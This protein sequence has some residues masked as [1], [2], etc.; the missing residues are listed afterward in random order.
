MGRATHAQD[1]GTDHAGRV[2]TDL[3]GRRRARSRFSSLWEFSLFVVVLL[4]VFLVVVDMA[5]TRGDDRVLRAA[6]SETASALVAADADGPADDPDAVDPN[7][8]DPNAAR[9]AGTHLDRDDVADDDRCEPVGLH[10]VGLADADA[11][12]TDAICLAKL[13]TKS[14]RS[15][16]RV[17][18]ERGESEVTVC[19]MAAARS[20]TGL[21]APFQRDRTLRTVAVEPLDESDP[22]LTWAAGERPLSGTDWDFCPAGRGADDAS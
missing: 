20:V 7:A 1:S 16:T 13:G 15:E 2:R 17:R 12:P 21:L 9:V 10:V 18:I 5:V 22:G 11:L 3:L 14:T 6:A 8:V 19:V 4:I